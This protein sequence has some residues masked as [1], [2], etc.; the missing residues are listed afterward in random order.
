MANPLSA[1][2][3]YTALKNEGVVLRTVGN[4]KT[5][6]R[7]G[8]GAWGPVHGVLI[9]HTVTSGTQ[10]TIDIVRH[11]YAGLPG[12]LCH[13]MIAKDGTVHLVGWGRTN[14]A[15][16]GDA[17]VLRKVIAEDPPYTPRSNSVD[18]NS[19]LYG[20]ECENLGN[21]KDPW[22]ARQLEAMVRATAA[23]CRAHGW[24]AGS[25]LG[26]KEWQVGKPDPV[27]VNMNDFRARV[28]ERLRHPASWSP[29]GGTYTVKKGD[30]LSG[31][32]EKYDTT[33]QKLWQLN[34][35]TMPQPDVL[36]VGQVIKV[37]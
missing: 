5:H 19:R 36:S 16:L 14:H 33:W 15:G 30:T 20:F 8:H 11:G 1:D 35:A 26:H 12:P 18:G 29:G 32:A 13:G 4:W 3:A 7:A 24:S 23:L 31:I 34:K 6:N 2:K 28:A 9:H 21:G 17:S 10:K 25:A 27:N 37:P 22:P